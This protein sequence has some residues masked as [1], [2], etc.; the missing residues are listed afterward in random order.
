MRIAVVVPLWESVPPPLYGGTQRVASALTEELVRRGH[1]VTL[2]A[3]G[4]S[5]T[6]AKLKS[7]YPRPL[8]RDGIPWTNALYPALNY[9]SAFEHADEFDVIH[10][11]LDIPQEYLALA[12]A[13][14]IKTPVV[15]TTHFLMPTD[16]SRDDEKQFL[17]FF[18]ESNFISISKSQQQ[19]NL[20]WV[21]SVHNGI[22]VSTFHFSEKPGDYFAWFGRFSE[23]KGAREAIIIAKKLGVKL[24]M[25]GKIDKAAA[26]KVNGDAPSDYEYYTEEVAPRIDGKQIRYI[27]ELNHQQKDKFLGGAKVLLNP[28]QWDEPFGLIPIEAMATGTPVISLRRGALVETVKEGVT[29]FLCDTIGEMIDRVRDLDIIDRQACRTHVEKNFSIANMVDGYEAV[30]RHVITKGRSS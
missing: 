9:I 8:Y 12:W 21:A 23:I 10:C 15:F 26:F 22:D 5:K 27:G 11:H 24:V 25:A 16:P 2:F 18:K 20:N 6:K 30:Y 19:L 3:T 4:D 28:I 17:E 1:T 14:Y 13:R 29:G 7:I